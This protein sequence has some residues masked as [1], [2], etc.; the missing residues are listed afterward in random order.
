MNNETLRELNLTSCE[1]GQTGGKTLGNALKTNKTL[2]KL[3]FI[4]NITGINNA[5]M[6]LYNPSRP[7]F[8]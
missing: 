2:R 3:R 6:D 5:R 7:P 8:F 1:I 4:G